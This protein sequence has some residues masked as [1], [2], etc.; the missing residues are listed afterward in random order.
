MMTITAHRHP[1]LFQPIVQRGN[2]PAFNAIGYYIAHYKT[3]D[4]QNP[5]NPTNS[6]GISVTTIDPG[7][8]TIGYQVWGEVFIRHEGY[9]ANCDTSFTPRQ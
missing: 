5:I 4:T 9:K 2:N 6:S 7:T 1:H 3:T 8:A